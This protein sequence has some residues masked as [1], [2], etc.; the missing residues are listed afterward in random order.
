MGLI[1]AVQTSAADNRDSSKTIPRLST[2]ARVMFCAV[3]THLPAT[4]AAQLQRVHA[5]DVATS[6]CGVQARCAAAT[7]LQW[8]LAAGNVCSCRG[9][10][11]IDV[12]MAAPCT[13]HAYMLL[14]PAM[15]LAGHM[16]LRR[17][18][19]PMLTCIDHPMPPH[20]LP[21][22]TQSIPQD[23]SAKLVVILR[24]H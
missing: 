22:K 6:P 18:K 20:I 1:L 19:L 21:C 5:S 2:A 9:A 11:H 10:V 16:Q 17:R 13:Q 7:A 24:P 3:L 14:H 12:P 4:Q 8:R 15:L 23:Y